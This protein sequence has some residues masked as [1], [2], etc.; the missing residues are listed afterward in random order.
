VGEEDE[1]D[2]EESELPEAFLNTQRILEPIHDA[3]D[4]HDAKKAQQAQH[5]R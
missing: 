4:A 3:D 5:L 1:D 2:R